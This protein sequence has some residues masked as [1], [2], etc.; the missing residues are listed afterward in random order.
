MSIEEDEDPSLATLVLAGVARV[1]RGFYCCLPGQVLK[2]NSATQS[3][4][5]QVV[6]VQGKNGE[7]G[8][9][10]EHIAPLVNVP[11]V[12]ARMGGF[13]LTMPVTV[14]S[15]VAVFFSSHAIA[16]WLATGVDLQDAGTDRRGA[17]SDAFAMPGLHPFPEA[18]GSGDV[19]STHMMIGA[20]GGTYQPVALGD[21]VETRLDALE[22]HRHNAPSTGGPTTAP[23]IASAAL[24]A[25]DPPAN[26]PNP[27]PLGGEV[28][29]GDAPPFTYTNGHVHTNGQ[30]LGVHTACPANKMTAPGA[31][32]DC[33]S[34]TVKVTV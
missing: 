9:E 8:R 33:R 18:L 14:G 10:T 16:K 17:L 13:H 7:D 1:L 20:D 29:G 4:T 32:S 34:G 24:A 28:N 6:T 23:L 22:S 11:I 3:A 25:Y 30:A 27:A 19:S 2:Y 26:I 21:T 15:R 5:V 31:S 12:F